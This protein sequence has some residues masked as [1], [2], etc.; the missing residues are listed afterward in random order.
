MEI[1]FYFNIIDLTNYIKNEKYLIYYFCKK[2]II[3]T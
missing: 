3:I 1:F 2:N